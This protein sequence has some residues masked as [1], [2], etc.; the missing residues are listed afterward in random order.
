MER[1]FVFVACGALEHVNTLLLSYQVLFKKTNHKIYVVTDNS[2]NEK[3]IDLE[4]LIDVKTPEKFDNHQAS[5]WLKTSLNKFLPSNCLYAYLDTDILAYG[6]QPD[7]IFENYRSPITFAPDHCKMDQ[8]SPYAG[9][10]GCMEMF[11]KK[12]IEVKEFISQ[13]DPLSNSTD[14]EVNKKRALLFE[15]FSKSKRNGRL[16]VNFYLKYF[17]SWPYFRIS[18]E[19]RYDKRKRLWTDNMENPLMYKVNMKRVAAKAGLK[20]NYLRNEMTLPDGRNLWSNYCSHLHQ[21]IKNKF[22]ID[23]K[24]I[25][26]Q[27]WNGGVFLFSDESN[28]FMNTWH[29]LTMEIFKD[30][31]WKTRDQGTLIATVWKLGLQDHPTLDKKWNLIMDYYNHQLDVLDDGSVT[32]DGRTK[33]FPELVHIYHHWED[34]S[35]GVWN[36]V[37]DKIN[38]PT[39]SS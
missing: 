7:G 10:C 8:F 3:K 25:N 38:K 18:D 36:Q 16:H 14:P 26:W 21:N 30:P 2:R 11:E 23:V 37:M 33:I 20:W 17:F 29:D 5:I 32:I 9:N 39:I 19:F 31:Q 28:E 35:W 15:T 12:R 1:A 34:T 6:K 4:N 13:S 27:H 22:G 24:Q